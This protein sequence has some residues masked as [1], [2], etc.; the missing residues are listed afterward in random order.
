M[1]VRPTHEML[2]NMELWTTHSLDLTLPV[3]NVALKV[4]VQRMSR[5]DDK[6]NL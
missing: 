6:V 3:C 4:L 1:S 2:K 5:S